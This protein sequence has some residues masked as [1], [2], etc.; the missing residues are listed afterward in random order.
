[1]TEVVNASANATPANV[2]NA[3]NMSASQATAIKEKQTKSATIKM[4]DAQ[5]RADV[6]RQGIQAGMKK[7]FDGIRLKANEIKVATDSADAARSEEDAASKRAAEV[8]FEAQKAEERRKAA[9][10]ALN[11][12]MEAVDEKVEESR[13]AMAKAGAARQSEKAVGE[14]ETPQMAAVNNWAAVAPE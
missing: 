4:E 10:E 5:R 11:N 12:A 2:A 14:E 9:E 7:Q 1:M 8:F 13:Q 6:T 3:T